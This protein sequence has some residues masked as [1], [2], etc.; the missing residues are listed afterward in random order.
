[1]SH[2]HAVVT[3]IRERAFSHPVARDE[4]P[5]AHGWITRTE[6]CACGARR[7]VNVNQAHREEG[8]WGPTR[9]E[10]RAAARRLVEEAQSEVRIDVAGSSPIRVKVEAM[11]R[12]SVKVWINGEPRFY[13]RPDFVVP[14]GTDG[15]RAAWRQLWE[16]AERVLDACAEMERA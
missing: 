12:D 15:V 3:S 14:D 7:E 1:M 10:R 2:T 16:R 11:D 4:N 9:D 6:E 8:P 5:A 13:S